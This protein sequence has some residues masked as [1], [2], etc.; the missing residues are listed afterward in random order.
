M[1]IAASIM[2]IIGAGT[3]ILANTTKAEEFITHLVQ[4]I[5]EDKAKEETERRRLASPPKA[6]AAPTGSRPKPSLA[7][8]DL[9]DEIPF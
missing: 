3:G 7:S 4:H 9:D 8:F 6:I 1:S 5:G 2:T